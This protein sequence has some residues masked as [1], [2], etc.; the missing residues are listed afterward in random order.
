[1]RFNRGLDCISAAFLEKLDRM[2][3]YTLF[4]SFELTQLGPG[5]FVIWN[6]KDSRL[7]RV[8]RVMY[9]VSRYKAERDDS[10]LCCGYDVRLGVRVVAL[11]TC[12]LVNHGEA[13]T[14]LSGPKSS[15]HLRSCE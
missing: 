10:S 13:L 1:M 14:G 2:D 3:G 11:R 6:V 8:L 7:L 12:D 15:V 4:D 5:K 9:S